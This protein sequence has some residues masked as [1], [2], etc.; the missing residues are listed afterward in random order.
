MTSEKFNQEATTLV[1][2]MQTFCDDKH[3][4]NKKTI[5]M[6][7]TYKGETTRLSACLC[8]ECE[9]LLGYAINRLENCP[10]EIKP[11]CRKCKAPCYERPRYKQMA[12][13]MMYSGVKLGLSKIKSAAGK[14][15]K[16]HD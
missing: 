2:F 14:L 16:R 11:K 3:T 8:D 10:H 4:G 12:K 15:F 5:D 7:I 1:K 9:E 13:M 6:N